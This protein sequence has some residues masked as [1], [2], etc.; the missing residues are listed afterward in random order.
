[1][2]QNQPALRRLT[3]LVKKEK[4]KKKRKKRKPKKSFLLH[5]PPASY[6]KSSPP[7]LK[8]KTTSY[9]IICIAI[10]HTCPA[11][12]LPFFFFSK[13]FGSC[14]LHLNVQSD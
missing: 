14:G 1:M 5:S 7:K 13:S 9:S 10:T 6:I 11:K 8:L 12:F 2:K 4:K 3:R